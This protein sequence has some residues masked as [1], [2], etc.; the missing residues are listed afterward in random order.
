MNLKNIEKIETAAQYDAVC[1]RVDE[2][3]DEASKKGLLESEY[4]NEYTREIGRL[5]HLGA[6]YENEYLK[7]E[8]LGVRKKSSVH[9]AKRKHKDT[10]LLFD[11]A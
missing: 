11:Y 9:K 4:D 3:I 1:V 8:H 10:I 5:S 7:F 6:V 2:L